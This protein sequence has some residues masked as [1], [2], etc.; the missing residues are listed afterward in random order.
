MHQSAGPE[1]EREHDNE[2]QN[3]E[4]VAAPIQKAYA[5]LDRRG[6]ERVLTRGRVVYSG[7]D[8]AGLVE[9]E[10]PIKD[11]SKTGCKIQNYYPPVP[12]S[13]VT[14]QLHLEDG[15]APLCF[16]DASVSWVAGSSLAVRFSRLSP[17]ERK[18][19]QEVIWK[20]VTVTA[21]NDRHTSFRIV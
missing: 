8:G 14:L 5:T 20:H 1:G 16:T 4:S 2:T 15:K 9:K 10:G 6:A 13:T 12:G 3:N 18:R 17:K 7:T 19:L 21:L 11:L